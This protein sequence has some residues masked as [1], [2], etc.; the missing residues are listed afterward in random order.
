MQKILE[1]FDNLFDGNKEAFGKYFLPDK[2]DAN[3]KMKGKASTVHKFNF[4][5][6]HE[7]DHHVTL[8][9]WKRHINGD[10]IGIVP[11]K[12]DCTCKFGAIDIDDYSIDKVELIEKINKLKLPLVPCSTKSGGTHLYCFTEAPVTAELMHKRLKEWAAVLGHAKNRDGR[13]TEI[14]PKQITV[15]SEKNDI[16][17]WINI[18]YAK[19]GNRYG[20]KTDGSFMTIEEFLDFAESKRVTEEVL[21]NLTFNFEDEF[22]LKDGP[23]CLQTLLAMGIPDGCRNNALYN[24]GVFFKNKFPEA[25]EAK[26]EQLNFKHCNPPL[27]SIDMQAIIKSLS[28]K[29]YQYKCNDM[30]ICSHCNSSVCRTRK[31]GTGGD[32]VLP[33]FASATKQDSDPPVWFIEVEIND[34]RCKLT[35]D[36]EELTNPLKFQRKLLDKANALM[37]VP[38]KKIWETIVNTALLNVNIIEM[39]QDASS[40]GQLV[41]YLERFC[42]TKAQAKVKEELLLGKPWSDSGRTYFRMTDFEEFL[43]RHKFVEFKTHKIVSIFKET[44]DLMLEHK[45]FNIKGTNVNTWSIKSFEKQTEGLDIPKELKDNEV[46]Y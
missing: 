44:K 20:L 13:D 8:D 40:S 22:G 4:R 1:R 3:G 25:W 6:C 26:L 2:A 29:T 38:T 27:Q 15:F 30:P 19:N 36:S 42:T 7:T 43:K 37:T 45:H 41:N 9:L 12:P 33:I 28:K 10:G 34:R 39:P 14:F 31:Y 35:L 18:P 21:E 17:H 16:G 23:P 11:I 32:M 46:I 5:E 24:Y